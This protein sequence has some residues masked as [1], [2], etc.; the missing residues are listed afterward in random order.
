MMTEDDIA[1]WQQAKAYVETYE[2]K[3][4]KT[5]HVYYAPELAYLAMNMGKRAYNNGHTGVIQ[6]RGSYRWDNDQEAQRVFPYA[7][8]ILEMNFSY[9]DQIR[10]QI[11]E[12]QYGLV[13]TDEDALYVDEAFMEESGYRRIDTLPLAVGNAHYDVDFWIPEE[14]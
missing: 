14:K 12:H 9:Q 8:E 2:R 3:D 11:R 6:R 1:N 13:T 4:D 10:A 5:Q 7:G